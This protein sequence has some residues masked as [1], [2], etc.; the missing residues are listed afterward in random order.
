MTLLHG[1]DFHD[2][3]HGAEEIIGHEILAAGTTSIKTPGQ[4]DDMTEGIQ[5]IPSVPIPTDLGWGRSLKTMP[6]IWA[7]VKSVGIGI[8]KHKLCL[9]MDDGGDPVCSARGSWERNAGNAVSVRWNPG[10]TWLE[11]RR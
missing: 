9:A 6:A 3:L 11:Y 8:K 10:A 1:D 4:Q 5:L 2:L 7:Q